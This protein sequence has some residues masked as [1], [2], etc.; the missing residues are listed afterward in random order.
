VLTRER[1]RLD[2]MLGRCWEHLEDRVFWGVHPAALG[3][4][5]KADPVQNLKFA[6]KSRTPCPEITAP[7]CRKV[8]AGAC[9][10]NLAR[11]R[12]PM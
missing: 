1:D 5:Q 3:H 4:G 10:L 6:A 8:D 12:K 2:G 9:S 7:T 11:R